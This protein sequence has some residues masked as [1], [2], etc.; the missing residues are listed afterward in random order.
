MGGSRSHSGNKDNRPKIKFCLYAFR[1][2]ASVLSMSVMG[3]QN[4]SLD[5]VGC[6]G[7]ALSSFL[8]IFLVF[9]FVKHINTYRSEGHDF[10]LLLRFHVPP[11]AVVKLQPLAVPQG[12]DRT[13]RPNLRLS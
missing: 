13:A 7:S 2:D 4:K 11:I 1:Y 6:V 8:C 9:N 5:G 12:F 3:V 10:M